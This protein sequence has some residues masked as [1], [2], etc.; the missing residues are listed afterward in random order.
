[1]SIDPQII[2]SSATL[3]GVLITVLVAHRSTVRTLTAEIQK[4]RYGVLNVYAERLCEARLL[5]YS[6]IYPLLSNTVKM[7]DY[8]ELF[9][10]SKDIERLE[11]Q[12]NVWDS[13]HG[14]LLTKESGSHAMKTRAAFRSLSKQGYKT[15]HNCTHN[16]SAKKEL[17][18]AIVGL[19][20]ALRI[21]LGIYALESWNIETGFGAYT[22]RE[23][24]SYTH[25]PP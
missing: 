8:P 3:L 21:D 17:A 1:M 23:M 2:A 10:Q 11:N 13:K 14:L 16:P 6:E 15:V 18:D 7:I 24:P 19:E 12:L 4:P 9:P 5:A 25:L 22:D 20:V